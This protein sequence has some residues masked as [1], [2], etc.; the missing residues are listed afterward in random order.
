MADWNMPGDDRE[1]LGVLRDLAELCWR[2]IVH[3][4]TSQALLL[5][6]EGTPI[7]EIAVVLP[8]M[9]RLITKEAYT[10]RWKAGLGIV[11]EATKYYT[12]GW[13]D[14]TWKQVVEEDIP[15]F[16][17]DL[18]PQLA[19]PQA[20]VMPR[21][22]ALVRTQDAKTVKRFERFMEG[23]RLGLAKSAAVRRKK[24]ATIMTALDKIQNADPQL[25][26]TEIARLYLRKKKE[27]TTWSDPEREVKVAN[28]TR[29][30][31]SFKKT[32]EHS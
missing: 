1:L 21:V 9:A 24:T 13:L 19:H 23:A 27:W 6:R 31:R 32:S 15:E 18:V 20:A 8:S 26:E 5:R 29:Q 4:L 10:L 30:R 14:D 17:D 22:N 3:E 7:N 25:A 2:F 28:L 11:A 16:I 12:A